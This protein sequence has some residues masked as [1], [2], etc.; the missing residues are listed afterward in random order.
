MCGYC[1]QGLSAVFS[2]FYCQHCSSIYPLLII[3]IVVAGL[4][5]VLVLFVLNFTVTDGSINAFILYANIISINTPVLFTKLN[6][7][8][9]TYTFISLANLDLGIQTCI[10]NGMD[11]YAKMWLQL[12]FPFYLIF[13]AT[14][15]IITSR[16]STTIQRLTARRALPVLATL[17]LLSY[18]KILHILSSVLFSYSTITHLPSKHTMVVWSVDANVPLF[19]VRFSIL[20]IVCLILFLIL[21]P[22]NVILLFTRT[23]SRFRIINKFKPLLDA[24]QGPYKNKYYFW[25]GIQL[26]IRAILF[27]LSSLDKNINLMVSG[28]CLGIIGGI[29][30]FLHPFKRKAKN[31]QELIF[32]LNLQGLFIISLHSNNST[33]VNVLIILAAVHFI[34][35]ITYHIITYMFGGVIRDKIQLSVNTLSEWIKGSLNKSPHQQFELQDVLHNKIPEVIYKYYEFREPLLCQD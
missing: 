16:Y 5:L 15:I 29:S 34:F 4:L 28:I 25:T 22:F 21:V 18:T 1:Q 9:P 24:Y 35:I 31:I 30:G 32:I 26:L 20:F 17:F 2:S 6:H 14:L 33:A 27:G 19:V 13:I 10:Y 8:T 7:F 11:D 12:T 23:L 3:P